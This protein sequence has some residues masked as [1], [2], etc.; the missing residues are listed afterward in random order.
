MQL[1]G[2]GSNLLLIIL[3]FGLLIAIHE[4]GH[5]LAAR[6]AGIR[7]DA[8]ELDRQR[9]AVVEH[10]ARDREGLAQRPALELRGQAARITIHGKPRRMKSAARS[11]IIVAGASRLPE[12]MAGIT[13]VSAIGTIS[14]SASVSSCASSPAGVERPGRSA[15][16]GP[17]G[18]VA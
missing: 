13:E 15:E 6:W 12:G 17:P 1:I 7:V 11:P 18:R 10:V 16:P 14:S 5:F 9:E 3:G 2:D 8:A 4:L